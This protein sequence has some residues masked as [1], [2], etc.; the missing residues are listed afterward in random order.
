MTNIEN[1]ALS[2]RR[3]LLGI[4][5]SATAATAAKAT[6]GPRENPELIGLADGLP[7][8]VA[9]YV[10]A[11]EKVEWIVA[12][13]GPQ[14]PVPSDEIKRYGAGCH[15]HVGIDGA[16]I[17]TP[18]GIKGDTHVASLGTPEHFEAGADY[19]DRMAAKKAKTKSKRGLKSELLW[20]ERDRAAIEPARVYWSEV[21]RIKEASGIDAAMAQRKDALEALHSHVD[22]IMRAEDRTIA[23]VVIKA[24]A[25]EAWKEAGRFARAFNVEGPA[26]ADLLSASIIRQSAER[27]ASS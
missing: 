26:W 18:Y 11:R 6:A 13:W 27:S 2:R 4:A 25:I 21:E 20:A 5:A 8:V 12:E 22:A 16:G 19:H 24:Q 17:A 15:R 14:W 10:A 9:A 3:V 23:S 1:A 7:A